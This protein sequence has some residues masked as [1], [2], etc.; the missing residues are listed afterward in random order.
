MPRNGLL[1]EQGSNATNMRFT[2]SGYGITRF[3]NPHLMH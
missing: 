1:A 3:R 2:A